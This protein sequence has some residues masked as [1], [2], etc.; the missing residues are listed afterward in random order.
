MD[1]D[2]EADGCPFGGCDP[3]FEFSNQLGTTSEIS[4]LNQ[5]FQTMGTMRSH[6]QSEKRRLNKAP[7]YSISLR[8]R[9]P[10]RHGLAHTV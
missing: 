1:R 3:A 10:G 5:T 9:L 6:K 4:T 7:S 8:T 2:F